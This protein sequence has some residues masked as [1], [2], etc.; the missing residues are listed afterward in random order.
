M[1]EERANVL[2]HGLGLVAAVAAVPVLVVAAVRS[3]GPADIVGAAV[4]G[5][6]LV[7]LYGASTAY[8]AAPAGRWKTRLRTLDHSAIFVLIAGTYTPFTLGVLGGGWGWSLFGLVWGAATIGISAKVWAG[9][10]FQSASTIA[11]VVMGWL[12]LIAIHPVVTRMS[13]AGIGW[14]VAGGLLYSGGVG[15]FLADRMKFNHFVWHVFVLGGS[16]CHFFAVLGHSA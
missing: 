5:A 14:L 3:G 11:Y 4:F 7:L 15:F 6:A 2:S 10:R 12:V 13:P 1:T 16:V 8:H 9:P